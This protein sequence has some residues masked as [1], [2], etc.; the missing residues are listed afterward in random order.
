MLEKGIPALDVRVNG[1]VREG[2]GG[3]AAVHEAVHAVV[4]EVLGRRVASV[5]AGTSEGHG[6]LVRST[7][8]R[9]A[10]VL[11]CVV[12]TLTGPAAGLHLGFSER[13]LG[14]S[15]TSWPQAEC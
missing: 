10:D 7:L 5:G 14:P 13:Q 3:H 1:L 4:G 11:V 8:D 15:P 2:L 12:P 6:E 9:Q